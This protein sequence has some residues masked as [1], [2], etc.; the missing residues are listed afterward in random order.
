M[1]IDLT[2][3][4]SSSSK[5][6]RGSKSN[7]IV[8]YEKLHDDDIRSLFIHEDNNHSTSTLVTSSYDN[9]AAVW[10]LSNRPTHPITDYGAGTGVLVG[11][12]RPGVSTSDTIL[13][14][15]KVMELVGHTD[16]VL[17]V[18]PCGG[19]GS[20]GGDVV[21]SSADGTVRLWRNVL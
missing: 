5:D 8:A 13:H 3:L 21:S 19:V 20:S 12:H 9:T 14:F 18:A 15:N 7:P 17:S 16:K 10:T 4:G 11:I 2:S 6:S 1:C